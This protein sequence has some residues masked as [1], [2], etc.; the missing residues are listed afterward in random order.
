MR[1]IFD[2]IFQF[3]GVTFLAVNFTANKNFVLVIK[4]T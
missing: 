2:Y 1:V 4:D 3:L